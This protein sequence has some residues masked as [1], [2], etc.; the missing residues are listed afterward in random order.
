MPVA[1]CTVLNSWWWTDRPSE[2]CRVSFQNKIN[3]IHWCIELVLLWKSW[4]NVLLKIIGE[5]LYLA[6][7][8]RVMFTVIKELPVP[9]KRATFILI[10]L[11]SCSALLH[12]L[13]VC[14]GILQKSVLRYNFLS[15][16]YPTSGRCTYANKDVRSRGYFSK[17]R[18]VRE[19]R[20]LGSSVFFDML[21]SVP[22]KVSTV[23]AH[24]SLAWR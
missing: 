18:A 19:R 15:F 23:T 1:V 8:L 14:F 7:C 6:I 3:L 12:M 11:K 20:N 5:L 10:K 17:W 9:T 13:P 21:P 4:N 24:E 22:G 16:G 2:T